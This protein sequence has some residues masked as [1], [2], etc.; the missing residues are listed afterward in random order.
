MTATLTTSKGKHIPLFVATL[1][2]LVLISVPYTISLV[3]IQWL[4]KI[5]H[6]RV[7]FWVR[8][9]KP[10][11]DAY[12]GPYR[13]NHRYWTG[14]LLLVRIV[15]LVIFSTNRINT[16]AVSIFSIAVFSFCLLAWLYFTGWI[17][18]SLIANCLELIFLL[19]LGL[20]STAIHFEISQIKERSS[21]VIDTSVGIT[22]VLFI[23]I[24][25][26]HAQKQL[27]STR[28]GT[29]IK[30]KISRLFVRERDEDDNA[31]IQLQVSQFKVEEAPKQVTY[32]VV[33]LSKPLLEDEKEN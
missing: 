7:M 18:E 27:F 33:A 17:Y 8:K 6:Y 2:L 11:F 23:V 32:S 26:Y 15:L 30:I 28:A 16:P 24:I 31:G 9:M 12:T 19:N 20:T 21:A 29:K 10:F 3:S 25:L 14:L 4:L 22:F 13:A 5:S 1:L